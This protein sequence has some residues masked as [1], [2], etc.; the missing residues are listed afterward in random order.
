[1]NAQNISQ[2]SNIPH[3]M[4]P[5]NQLS[6]NIKEQRTLSQIDS[7]QVRDQKPWQNPMLGQEDPRD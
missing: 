4:S 2:I 3:S 6:D 7:Q 1:M 5:P